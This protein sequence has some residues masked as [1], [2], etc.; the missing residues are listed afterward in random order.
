MIW[1]RFKQVI[2]WQSIFHVTDNVDVCR[3]LCRDGILSTREKKLLFTFEIVLKFIN[4]DNFQCFVMIY[5][6]ILKVCIE[7]NNGTFQI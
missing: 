1:Y 2:D 7:M 4:F 3:L 6:V 5:M